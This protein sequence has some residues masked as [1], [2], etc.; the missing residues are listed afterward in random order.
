M[1]A[2]FTTTIETYQSLMVS[3]MPM[4]ETHNEQ[5]EAH[6]GMFAHYVLSVERVDWARVRETVEDL[7]DGAGITYSE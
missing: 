4:E 5:Y 3:T 6:D 7:L 2:V 1:R